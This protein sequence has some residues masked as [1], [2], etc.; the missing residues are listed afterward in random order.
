M[1]GKYV[2]GQSGLV[3]AVLERATRNTQYNRLLSIWEE[4]IPEYSVQRG[5]ERERNHQGRGGGDGSLS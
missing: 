1:L 5:K 2:Q 4:V 3:G